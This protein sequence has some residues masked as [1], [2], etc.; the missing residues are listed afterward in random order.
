ME[1]YTNAAILSELS[2]LNIGI[3]YTKLNANAGSKPLCLFLKPKRPQR[4][5]RLAEFSF[6]RIR[7]LEQRRNLNVIKI[8]FLIDEETNSERIINL[9]SRIIIIIFFSGTLQGTS[10]GLK[11]CQQTRQ[12]W[13]LALNHTVNGGPGIRKETVAFYLK[14]LPLIK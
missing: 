10:L 14:E 2:F 11:I 6:Y 12:M 8:K 5:I 3:Q 13:S 7:S 9:S 4:C 1:N